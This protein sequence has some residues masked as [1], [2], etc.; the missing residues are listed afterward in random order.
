MFREVLFCKIDKI[1]FADSENQGRK[2]YVIFGEMQR[3]RPWSDIAVYI[4]VGNISLKMFDIFQF[5]L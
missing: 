3:V 1:I 5:R 2:R 4:I